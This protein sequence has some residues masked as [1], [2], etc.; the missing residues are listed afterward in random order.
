MNKMD[1][2]DFDEAVFDAIAA[3]FTGYASALGIH[4][5]DRDPDL[6]AARRQRRDPLRADRLVRRARRC[7]STW[8]RV[9]RPRRR[10][11]RPLRFPVQYVIRPQSDDAARLPRLRR[12]GRLR[13]ASAPGD[14][15]VV[16][17]SGTR[18]TRR[19]HRHCS[20]AP[21]DVAVAPMSVTLRLDRRPR[22]L[23]RRP[24]RRPPASARPGH[25]D[26]RRHRRAGSPTS[27][28]APGAR[29]CV[30][31]GTRTVP[32]DRR[33]R[34]TTGWTS[35]RSAGTSPRELAAQRHRP[36]HPAHRRAAARRRLRRAPAHRVASCSS[37]TRT[38]PR[39]SAGM[40]GDPL[41]TRTAGPGRC[42]TADRLTSAARRRPPVRLLRGAPVTTRRFIALATRLPLLLLAA[43]G[44][45]AGIAAA[46][47]ADVAAVRP[48]RRRRAAGDR[49]R[50]ASC[51]SATS[52][53][54]PTP[55]PLVGVETGLLR[56]GASATPSWR[57][58]SSTPARPRSRRCSPARSTP[59]YIGPNPA[60]NAFA[61]T[62]GEA[63]R[64]IAGATIGRRRARRR[65]RRSTRPADLKGKTLATPQLGNTQDV[66][67]RVVAG[68][69]G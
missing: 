59:T 11:P 52:P 69:Q 33:A 10:R 45:A 49:P 63:I 67:L 51:G 42:Q 65:S 29:C 46:S 60:I 48:R 47:S 18:T 22:R 43:C 68:R 3:E 16:L 1:L 36:G 9:D 13:R 32:G 31:H 62:N 7:S 12:P 25:Q 34:S 66:A 40:V 19:R 26:A 55:P 38:A 56:R 15:V 2:V 53:T 6:G 5:V 35:T 61:K 20:T 44:S 50:R 21:S 57:P 23:P 39:S 58:R 37:T 4:E 14:E 54:S 41:A 8:R 28:C 30:K 17:P 64:I 27:R 24:D